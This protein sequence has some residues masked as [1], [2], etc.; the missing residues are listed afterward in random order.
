[1]INEVIKNKYLDKS[2]ILPDK[3]HKFCK[4]NY[5]EPQFTKKYTKSEIKSTSIEIVFSQVQDIICN[6]TEDTEQKPHKQKI[7]I[8]LKSNLSK[9]KASLTLTLIGLRLVPIKQKR[10]FKGEFS[11]SC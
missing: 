10:N 5:N 4:D 7:C 3:Y 1:M 6:F 11:A 2:K 9:L 8:N